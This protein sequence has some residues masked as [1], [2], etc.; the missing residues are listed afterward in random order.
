[1]INKSNYKYT[2]YRK[3]LNYDIRVAMLLKSYCI[4]TEGYSKQC[5]CIKNQ[6]QHAPETEWVKQR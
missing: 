4:K 2:L 5:T 1:M 6:S 3:G